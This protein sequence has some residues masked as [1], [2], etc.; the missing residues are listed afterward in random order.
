MVNVIKRIYEVL[1]IDKIVYASALGDSRPLLLASHD[2]TNIDHKNNFNF[3]P[4]KT[5]FCIN[6]CVLYLIIFIH[7]NLAICIDFHK[8]V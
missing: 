1:K 4:F 8:A 5:A 6:H 3:V 2:S 7:G